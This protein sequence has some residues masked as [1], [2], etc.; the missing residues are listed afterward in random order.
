MTEHR[1]IEKMLAL[2]EREVAAMTEESYDPIF[3]DTVVD[4]IKTYAD[5]T[6]HGKEEN[7]LFADLGK[8]KLDDSDARV[9]G[10]LIEEHRQARIKVAWIVELNERN[11]HGER[12]TAGEI[13]EIV[14]W[15]AAF[16]PVHI[17][18][19]DDRFFPDTEKYFD[20]REMDGMLERFWDF[21]KKMIHV[22][23]REL[24]ES[25]SATKG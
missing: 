3:I 14:S 23:Y 21:D 5:R 15:L 18:K 16:Y 25:L 8:K 22:K 4:F 19:E 12:G 1:L 2:A 6:H 9:M 10:E 20:E 13:K 24:F 7:I 17:K 11:K